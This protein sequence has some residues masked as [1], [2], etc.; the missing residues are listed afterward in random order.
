MK[1]PIGGD[2][3]YFLDLYARFLRD[4]SSVPA[5]WV[6]H[7]TEMETGY[8]RT[9]GPA[10]LVQ[11]FLAATRW[12]GH[13][14]AEL[15]PL[16][17]NGHDEPQLAR[18]R[19]LLATHGKDEINLNI[20]GV[21]RG[22]RVAEASHLIKSIYSGPIGLEAAHLDHE[23]ERTWLHSAF[24]A[25]MLSKPDDELVA[26]TLE[27]IILADEFEAFMRVKFPTKKRFG[28]EG[29]E[30]S[31]VFVRDLLKAA[32]GQGIGEV[33]L[34]GMHRGRL[35]LLAAAL[36]KSPATLAAELMGRDLSEGAIFTGDVPYHLGYRAELDF[37]Q[38][39]LGVTLL[40]HPSHLLVVAPVALGLAR[41]MR[42]RSPTDGETLCV[43]MH[44][45]AAFSGQG[46]ASELLQ[47]SGLKGYTTGGTV[48]I[49]VNNQIGFTTLPSE[50][51][52]ARYC[53][54]AAKLIGAPVFHVN[55][56]DPIAV[57]RVAWLALA[58]RQRFHKDV[59]IDLVCYR[60]YGH[61]ELDEPRFTQPGMWSRIDRHP[62]LREH[63]SSTALATRPHLKDWAEG[64]AADFRERLRAGFEVSAEISPNDE[65]VQ[66]PAWAG[67]QAADEA[68]LLRSV[69]TGV[70][71]EELRRIG[72]AACTLPERLNV[73]PKVHRFYEQ[74]A[75]TISSGEGINFATAEALA[76]AT[77]LA[78]GV[79]VRLSGQ[80]AVRGTFTQRHMAVHDISDH[81]SVIPLE[82]VA[83]QP[84]S[85]EIINSP[86]SE[87]GVLGFEYGHSLHD[88]RQLT[89]WEAQFGDFI[90]GAQ[91]V[92]DQYIVSAEA[93]WRLRSGLVVLLP[94]GLE[95]QGPDHSSA[96]IE[97]LTQ[98]CAGGNILIANP[99][100][101]ANLFHLLRRQ[102]H[103]PWRKPLFVIAPKSLLRAKAAVS[104]LA[105][106]DAGTTFRPIIADVPPNSAKIRRIVMCS[107]KI[108]Y[109]FDQARKAA[110]LEAEILPLRIEQI[111]PFPASY[112]AALLA[113]FAGTEL[114]WLQEEAVNQGAWPY[115]SAEFARAGIRL[116]PRCPVIARP[117]LS[118]TAGGSVERHARE[119]A[120]LLEAALTLP[121]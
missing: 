106:M 9:P 43:L 73:N 120:A 51:R 47:L 115:L 97:R 2:N 25:A 71:L 44:T 87:Y 22:V 54:D 32:S 23:E 42:H 16:S 82:Q 30:G 27:S 63:F 108:F 59:L 10:A 110:G 49:V 116:S 40:P 105:E 58:W 70:P 7:F 117:A 93:K 119:E 35:A 39:K 114:V 53:T 66:S 118:V 61:N 11:E 26:G 79:P 90:N 81:R 84:G 62:P 38:R 95:G 52:T 4:E 102:I 21:E 8:R 112:L 56:D 68:A 12:L 6:A 65:P 28:S 89:L 109:A 34:G 77:L 37:Q 101:P 3:A 78:E 31:L 60:R 104:A 100:T 55:G 98:L 94:H 50:G 80:D 85:F 24:E 67:L 13:L 74:R 36:G 107:G 17:H 86:L 69:P 111:Y 46:L 113:P 48:H 83:Q 45:D 64:V 18:L 72:L 14:E 19:E 20:G 1:T 96:R 5:D 15:D 33:V 121:K 103:A 91:V 76:F 75:E 88:P 29:S 92:V 57:A 99:S 41:A